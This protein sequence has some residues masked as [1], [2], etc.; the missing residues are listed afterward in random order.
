M[1]RV[2]RS[3]PLVGPSTDISNFTRLYKEAFGGPPYF[4]TYSDKEVIDEIWTP[5]IER[6]VVVLA[7]DDDNGAIIGFGCAIPLIHAPTDV[8][9]FLKSSWMQGDL[10]EELLPTKTW[11]MSELGVATTHRKQGVAYKLVRDRLISASH[12][13]ANHY[14]MR[15]AATQS[16]S[17]HLYERA[18]AE[19]LGRKQDISDTGQVTVNGSH[20]TSRV[21]LY[22]RTGD[23]LNI[24]A[25]L[26]EFDD[27]STV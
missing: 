1:I 6:G 9:D 25:G 2:R 23:A 17:R 22:G 27:V 4:E 14:V 12:S 13:G 15:T 3:I 11:Y 10:P 18:G 8:Q 7:Y 20:S 24:V 16:N 5:H 21:Y 26:R 19:Q